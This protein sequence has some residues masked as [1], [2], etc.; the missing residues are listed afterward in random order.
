MIL[1]DSSVY[2]QWL[3]EHV[4]PHRKLEPWIR[5]EALWTCGVIRVEV[6]RG[7]RHE[8]QKA[9]I[10][11]FFDLLLEVP[12]DTAVWNRTAELAWRLDRD[13]KV[14]SVSD[15]VIGACALQVNAQVITTNTNL[16]HIAG[17]KCVTGI[18]ELQVDE[19]WTG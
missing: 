1:V 18:D 15:L 10:E 13:G 12:C 5:R 6:L 7:I 8:D 9:R 19:D 2:I 16:H 3:R 17:L 14:L 4:E 11:Y